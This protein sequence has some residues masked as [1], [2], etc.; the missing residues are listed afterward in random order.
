R[1]VCA[2]GPIAFSL[3]RR[4]APRIGEVEAM[5]FTSIPR[6]CDNQRTE[7]RGKCVGR[8]RLRL[9]TLAWFAVVTPTASA[10]FLAPLS[11]D[12]GSGPAAVALADFNGDG[13]PDLVTADSGSSTISVLLGKGDGT[14]GPARSFPTGNLPRS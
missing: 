1:L 4:P 12:T 3:Y 9:A 13:I 5:A 6:R 8:Y 10:G 2:P 14:F 11:F 7:S